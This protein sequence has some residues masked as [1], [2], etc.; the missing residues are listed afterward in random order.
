M[1]SNLF[2]GRLGNIGEACNSKLGWF[3]FIW[4]VPLTHS[5]DSK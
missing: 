1:Y 4:M 3:H 5:V 2:K